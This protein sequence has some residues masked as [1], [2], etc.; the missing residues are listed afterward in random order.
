VTVVEQDIL[1]AKELGC[2]GVVIGALTPEFHL[3]VKRLKR[4]KALAGDMYVTFHRA[5]DVVQEPLQALEQLIDLGFDCVLTS[6]QEEKAIQGFSALEEWNNKL[7]E[8]IVIMP[9]SG[10]SEKNCVQYKNAGFKALHL[11]GSI[12][13]DPILIP[14]GVNREMSFLHQTIVESNFLILKNVVQ[15]VTD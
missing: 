12:A 14:K 15:D 10:I 8:R 5:F 6:G 11:S 4:W 3:D 13:I 7:G 1:T 2:K 9:G